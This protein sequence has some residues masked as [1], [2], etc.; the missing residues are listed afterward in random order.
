LLGLD[1]IV[2]VGDAFG[3]VPGLPVALGNLRSGQV[4]ELGQ[5]KLAELLALRAAADKVRL[6][7]VALPQRLEPRALPNRQ[8]PHTP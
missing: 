1:K 7:G 8:G 4:N 2:S 5:V 3:F 6:R